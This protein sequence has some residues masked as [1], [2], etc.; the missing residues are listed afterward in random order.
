METEDSGAVWILV[1]RWGPDNKGETWQRVEKSLPPS[2][3]TEGD[4]EHEV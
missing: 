4:T 2:L 3:S 1:D